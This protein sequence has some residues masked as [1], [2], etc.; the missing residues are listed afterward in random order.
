MSLSN[1]RSRSVLDEL[2][3]QIIVSP[4]PANFGSLTSDKTMQFEIFNANLAST[5]LTDVT[6]DG[7]DGVL[8]DLSLPQVFAALES[9]E[10]DATADASEIAILDG[11]LNYIFTTDVYYQSVEGASF[12]LLETL[13]DY[14]ANPVET[15]NWKTN[16]TES[17]DGHEQR[18]QTIRNPR[19]DIQFFYTVY[20]RERRLLDTFIYKNGGGRIVL[21]LQVQVKELQNQV[22]MGQSIITLDMSDSLIQDNGLLLLSYGGVK[23]IAQIDTVDRNTDTILLKTA[24]ENT[25]PVGSTVAPAL[26]GYLPDSFNYRRLTDELSQAFLVLQSNDNTTDHILPYTNHTFPSYNGFV[27]FDQEPNRVTDVVHRFETKVDNINFNY[28]I[29]ERVQQFEFPKISFDYNYLFKSRSELSN[30]K[31]FLNEV[32]K[33]KVGT[34]LIPSFINDFQPILDIGS[35][36]TAIAVENINGILYKDSPANVIRI[37]TTNGTIYYRDLVNIIVVDDDRENLVINS[38]LGV[39][40]AAEDVMRIELVME[41]RMDSDEIIINYITNEVS[42]SIFRMKIMNYTEE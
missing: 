29:R 39:D 8:L 28:G 14:S 6:S 11:T 24:M 15:L 19:M 9:F 1:N 3:N 4:D 41:G 38:A 34:F 32:A 27:V 37:I 40:L 21:P 33:G 35:T 30:F 20:K 13:P 22:T 7:A 2:Y 36:D 42:S 5:T 25:F 10:F 12:F 23:E 16:I 17:F 26:S 18:I 31:A